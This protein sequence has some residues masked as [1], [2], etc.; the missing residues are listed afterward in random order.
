LDAP[1]GVTRKVALTG[2]LALPLFPLALNHAAE[3]RHGDYAA[4]DFALNMLASV[5][6]GAILYSSEY[7][8]FHGPATYF[9][10]VENVRADVLILGYTPVPSFLVQMERRYPWAF[11]GLQREK[12]FYLGEYQRLDHGNSQQDYIHGLLNELIFLILWKDYPAR[13]VY[14]T[15]ATPLQDDVNPVPEGLANRLYKQ[16]DVPVSPI[17]SLTVRPISRTDAQT[18]KLMGDYARAYTNQGLYRAVILGDTALGLGF[19][20]EALKFDPAFAPAH[21]WIQRL[22]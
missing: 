2:A 4:E 9:Q 10:L 8:T 16:E 6:P 3:N 7:K 5:E 12:S 11:N 22:R 21:Q 14:V 13:P 17:R 18:K 15:Q 1:G 20:Q 19:L